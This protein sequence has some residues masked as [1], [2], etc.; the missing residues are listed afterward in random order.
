M[1]GPKENPVPDRLERKRLQNR[2]AQQK[3]R[4][5]VRERMNAMEKQIKELQSSPQF[6][7]TAEHPPLT[8]VQDD[9]H[10]TPE[11]EPET[12]V[13]SPSLGTRFS[14]R[15]SIDEDLEINRGVSTGQLSAS[16]QSDVPSSPQ[17]LQTFTP[18]MSHISSQSFSG[19]VWTPQ[20][21]TGI[22]DPSNGLTGETTMAHYTFYDSTLWQNEEMGT[23]FRLDGDIY[24]FEDESRSSGRPQAKPSPPLQDVSR[25]DPHDKALSFASLDMAVDIF[26]EDPTSR[27]SQNQLGYPK[28]KAKL[29]SLSTEKRFEYL[30]H[31]LSI[32]G[33]GTFDSMA[34]QYYTTDFSHESIM[35]SQQR[36]SRQRQLPQLLMDLRQHVKTWTQWEAH[37]YCDEIIRSAESIIASEKVGSMAGQ[38]QCCNK[39]LELSGTLSTS[40][41]QPLMRMFQETRTFQS[42][43]CEIVMRLSHHDREQINEKTTVGTLFTRDRSDERQ[44][45]N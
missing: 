16:I 35:S 2:E 32:A 5:R 12:S 40:Q 25:A 21:E 30:H 4:S 20:C 36:A 27:T 18:T 28:L 9:K 19:L 11:L 26:S 15:L 13:Y 8:S 33:F 31:C 23:D 45:K 1:V 42:G 37:G 41:L 17:S 7:L 38:T 10:T 39:L 3:Y 22:Q 14:K 34:S 29:T 44:K 6:S 43:R 24:T